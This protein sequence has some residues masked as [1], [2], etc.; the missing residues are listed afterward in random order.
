MNKQI[1][2]FFFLSTASIRSTE[3]NALI[4]INNGSSSES[5]ALIE[6]S[7]T[8]VLRHL[9]V[10]NFVTG[11][12]TLGKLSILGAVSVTGSNNY[13]LSAL[14]VLEVGSV[15]QFARQQY[16]VKKLNQTDTSA[17]N[18]NRL[19]KLTVSNV[20]DLIVSIVSTLTTSGTLLTNPKVNNALTNCL[21]LPSTVCAGY[22]WSSIYGNHQKY[23]K[24]KNSL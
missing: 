17:N 19:Q 14:A 13:H 1:L 10:N 4:S 23:K 12:L 5:T 24:I 11:A 21:L 2:F 15:I 22:L 18:E 9:T 16:F 7:S 20:T 3:D 8:G 6:S